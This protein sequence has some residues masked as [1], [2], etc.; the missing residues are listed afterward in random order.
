MNKVRIIG[1]IHGKV[2]D[3][4]EIV[5]FTKRSIQV[6]DYGVGFGTGQL[7][8]ICYKDSKWLE[9]ARVNP[10]HRFIRGNHDNPAVCKMFPNYIPDMTIENDVMFL[11]GAWS[12]DRKMR[13][14]GW[15]WW[16]DEELS[17]QQLDI[18]IGMYEAARPRI[19]IT[20]DCPTSVATELFI[21]PRR[22]TQYRTR[23][24][25]AL[26]EMFQRWKPELHIFGHWHHSVQANIDGTDFI[27]LNELEYIDVD[28][29][30]G[31]ILGGGR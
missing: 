4:M 19:M 12:I 27:C 24:A 10:E 23:T 1:D 9:W 17:Y 14:E 18:A 28:L 6:G 26:E 30:T 8:E 15:D 13:L 3:Y 20:H 5:A 11:G 25:D 2:R 29:D 31:E 7:G 21:K 16:E 22:W